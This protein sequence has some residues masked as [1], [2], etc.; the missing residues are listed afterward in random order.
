MKLTPASMAAWMA[1]IAWASS[2]RPAIDTY[3]PPRPIALTRGPSGPRRR[4]FM[5]NTLQ[6]GGCY[7][8][9]SGA[10]NGSEGGAAGQDVDKGGL[11]PE[12]AGVR[13]L[14]DGA[15]DLGDAVLEVRRDPEEHGAA[16]AGVR[17]VGEDVARGAL[18]DLEEAAL[19][20]FGAEVDAEGDGAGAG[21]VVVPRVMVRAA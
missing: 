2:G 16:G 15:S 10:R 18:A 5:M 14:G 9:A 12:P 13:C 11:L 21:N 3:M 1:R 17:D 6:G 4:C 20:G 7:G 8:R 19:I